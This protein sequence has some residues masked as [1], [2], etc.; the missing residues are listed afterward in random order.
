MPPISKDGT[1]QIPWAL[2]LETQVDRN[3]RPTFPRYLKELDG[4]EVSLSGFMQPIT[5][6]LDLGAM[7]LI[8]YPTGCWYCE[9]P[10]VSGIVLVELPDGKTVPFTRSLVKVTGKLS[11]NA[12]DP[13][14][15]LYT[16]KEA[17]VV[18]AD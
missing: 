18:E 7:M 14:N 15:F 12:A 16:I 11:L 3:Y 17:R 13:E 10:E 8:E 9:M 2:L 5:E 4:L 6:E 1:N